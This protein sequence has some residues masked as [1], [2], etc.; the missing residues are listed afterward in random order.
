MLERAFGW[1]CIL[2]AEARREVRKLY[3]IVLYCIEVDKIDIDTGYLFNVK[4]TIHSDEF[5]SSSLY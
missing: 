3:C 4:F 5:E 1:D 2:V